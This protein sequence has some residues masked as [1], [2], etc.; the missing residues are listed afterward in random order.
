MLLQLTDVGKQRETDSNL[1]I[2]PMSPIKYLVLFDSPAVT[3][4]NAIAA[5]QLN[6]L[7]EV[8]RIDINKEGAVTRLSAGTVKL[9]G[10]ITPGEEYYIRGVGVILEDGDFY[11][12]APYKVE[13]G[14]FHKPKPLAYSFFVLHSVEDNS[15]MEFE[16]TPLDTKA[17]AAAVN[18]M[19]QI[20]TFQETQAHILS[21]QSKILTHQL[22]QENKIKELA[23]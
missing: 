5:L 17:M 14:G 3:D 18:E 15:V 21:T 6:Q 7:N 4:T 8:A 9:E 23:S 19:L 12:Y 1:G 13:N 20:D 22:K 16:Y 2:R 10:H 11:Q